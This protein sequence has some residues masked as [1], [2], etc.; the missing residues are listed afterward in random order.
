MDHMGDES[1]SEAIDLPRTGVYTCCCGL[2]VSIDAARDRMALTTASECKWCFDVSLQSQ[3]QLHRNTQ[4]MGSPP[5]SQ[6]SGGFPHLCALKHIAQDGQSRD[7]SRQMILIFSYW[8]HHPR[9]DNK[10]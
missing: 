6:D 9:P 7:A 4:H 3:P 2:V 1:P 8:S 5:L 10:S